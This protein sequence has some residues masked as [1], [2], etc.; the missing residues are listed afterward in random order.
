MNCDATRN[1]TWTHASGAEHG[2]EFG[3]GVNIVGSCSMQE[4]F[5]VVDG[6]SV[7]PTTGGAAGITLGPIGVILRNLMAHSTNN[8]GF[9]LGRGGSAAFPGVVENC[10]GKSDSSRGFDIR[11]DG[12]DSHWR[13]IN[14]TAMATGI[15][16]GFIIG[17]S[18][19][20]TI[21]LELVNNVVNGGTVGS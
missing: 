13:V 3:E 20:Y 2:G 11:A 16:Q 17:Q 10:V 5:A 19:S 8:R 6:L 1:V 15:N 12:A 18:S 9:T 4:S 21:N 14:C 7:S